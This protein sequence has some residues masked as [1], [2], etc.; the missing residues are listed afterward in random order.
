MAMAEAEQGVVIEQGVVA[1]ESAAPLRIERLSSGQTRLEPIPGR[2]TSG[3]SAWI[4]DQD[5]MARAIQRS[6]QEM[7]G[8]GPPPPPPEVELADMWSS[9]TE[10]PYHHEEEKPYYPNEEEE[11]EKLSPRASFAEGCDP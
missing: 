5:D 7:K 6:L 4:D 10:E 9:C 2:S 8:D 11:R 3:A 1:A